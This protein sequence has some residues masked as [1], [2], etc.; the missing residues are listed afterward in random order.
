MTAWRSGAK[1]YQVAVA[2]NT[3]PR[4]GPSVVYMLPRREA[5]EDTCNGK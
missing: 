3:R 5:R 4:K 2:A 1:K